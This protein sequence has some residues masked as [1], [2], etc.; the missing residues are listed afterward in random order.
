MIP[1]LYEQLLTVELQRIVAAVD[2]ARIDVVSPEAAD[3]HIAVAEHLRRV[4]ERAL[5]SV[6]EE[7]RLTRQAEICNALVTWLRHEQRSLS[8][9]PD[10][11]LV[12]PLTVLREVRALAHGAAPGYVSHER[13]RPIAITWRL[14]TPMPNDFFRE[15]KV[16]A[17]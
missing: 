7:E 8:V 11:A 16:A 6:P 1:G 14:R 15:A 2:A 4:L 13:S 17:G 5:R 9:E 10:D 3:A 12:V